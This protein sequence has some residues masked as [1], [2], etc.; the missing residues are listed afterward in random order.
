MRG[1]RGAFRGIEQAIVF[2][3][4]PARLIVATVTRHDVE[5]RARVEVIADPSIARDIV[6][7]GS[8]RSRP[9]LALLII[10]ADLDAEALAP[11]L[12]DRL[13]DE[14]MAFV[15]VDQNFDFRK[16]GATGETGLGEKFLSR[17]EIVGH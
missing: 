3:V 17:G 4:F 13:G 15:G 16:T 8:H 6:V 12:L 2:G 1:V 10:N 9:N 5:K 11:H 14:A 7:Q